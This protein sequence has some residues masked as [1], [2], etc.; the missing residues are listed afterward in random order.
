MCACMYVC[1]YVYVS[2]Y[3]H[4]LHYFLKIALQLLIV[5]SFPSFNTSGEYF[6]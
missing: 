4:I 2:E 5:I 1:V 6:N 3:S